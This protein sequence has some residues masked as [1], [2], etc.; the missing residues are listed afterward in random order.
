MKKT[1]HWKKRLGAMAIAGA[2]TSLVGNAQAS[3]ITGGDAVDQASAQQILDI[4]FVID[5]SGSMAD[6]IVAIGNTAR[7][8]I[9][10]LEC[11]DCDVW[12]RARFMGITGNSGTLFNENVRSYVIGKSGTPTSNSSEDNGPAVVDLINYYDFNNDAVG[13]Q[14]YFKAIVT[15]GDEGTQDGAPVALNDYD[16]ALA[17]NQAAIAAGVFLF[18]WVSDDP[19]PGV[20]TL[21]QLMAEGG[22]NPNAPSNGAHVFGDTGGAYVQQGSNTAEVQARLQEIICIAATGGT[23]GGNNVPDAGMTLGLLGLSAFGLQLARKRLS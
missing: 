3:L 4:V 18:S 12:V 5:T 20:T 23:G 11:P 9:E 19:S 10:N 14:Q 8:A 2:V 21:F 15:I 13:S 7:A 17:A 6:D 22:T 1:L 16:A